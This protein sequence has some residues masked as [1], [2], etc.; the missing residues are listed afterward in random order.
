MGVGA[1]GSLYGGYAESKAAKLQGKYQKGIAE[2]NAQ[3][4]ELQADYVMRQGK[5]DVAKVR[6]E[7]GQFK[8]KQRAILAGQ[9]VDVNSGTA[10]D[11]QDDTQVGG[12]LDAITVA[13]N[14][15]RE[16]WG[17]KVQATNYR[18]QGRMAEIGATAKAKSTLLVGGMNAVSQVGQAAYYARKS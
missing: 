18:Y 10:I 3:M 17:L 7:A 15:F 14:A 12:E 5:K 6:R 13:N 8:G 11:L 2:S 16:A 9:G 4:S 1:V